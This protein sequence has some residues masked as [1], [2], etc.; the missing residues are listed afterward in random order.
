MIILGAIPNSIYNFA[1]NEWKKVSS[2]R[3]HCAS[4]CNPN[5]E[6]HKEARTAAIAPAGKAKD[7]RLRNRYASVFFIILKSYTRLDYI[8]YRNSF[9]I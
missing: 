2:I 8:C 9:I 7:T 3:R 5:F 6:S 4:G 1:L